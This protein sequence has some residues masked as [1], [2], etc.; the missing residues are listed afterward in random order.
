MEI[1]KKQLVFRGELKVRD[2]Y[3]TEIIIHCS[4]TIEGH[5]VPVE[6][7]HQLHQRKP[8]NMIG[9][10]YHYY[11]DLAGNIWEGRPEW[12][13]GA[14]TVGHNQQ[15]IGICYCGGLSV[16]NTPKDTRTMAQQKAMKE[17][18]A[19]LLNKYPMAKV[20]GHNQWAAKAC[21]SF[22]AAEWA[23][24]NGFAND[25]TINRVK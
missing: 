19:E 6:R 10:G 24:R 1:K 8:F 17:L 12:V 14:H 25:K 20:S 16:Y 21:P 5:D 11:I 3:P 22:N 7:I 15:S 2:K 23:E 13:V 9:I 4:A 18:V